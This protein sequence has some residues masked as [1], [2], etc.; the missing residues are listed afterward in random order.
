VLRAQPSVCHIF[1]PHAAPQLSSTPPPPPL[2]LCCAR[3]T[4]PQTPLY[5][6]V[7]CTHLSLCTR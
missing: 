2:L 3:I 1:S 7:S 4:L 5:V 6:V